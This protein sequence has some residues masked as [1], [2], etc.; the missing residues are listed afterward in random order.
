PNCWRPTPRKT[1]GEFAMKKNTTFVPRTWSRVLAKVRWGR[2]LLT[3]GLLSSLGA[4]A[5]EASLVLPDLSRVSGLGGISGWSILTWGLLICVFGL[6]FGLVQ[7]MKLK[8][9]PVHRA[10]LEISELIYATCKTYLVTQGKFILILEIFIGIIMFVYFGVLRALP[11]G[12]V[13]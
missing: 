4:R 13:V 9:L 5:D 1:Q 11:F 2:V 6:L 12:T 7:Y 10:M 3:L 8:K